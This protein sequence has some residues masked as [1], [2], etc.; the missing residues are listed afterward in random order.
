VGGRIGEVVSREPAGD[1]CADDGARVLSE[2]WVLKITI[3]VPP[4]VTDWGK[5]WQLLRPTASFDQKTCTWSTML[6]AIDPAALT[7]LQSCLTVAREYRAPVQVEVI[8]AP[9]QWLG[10]VFDALPE[11]GTEKPFE[12]LN[13]Q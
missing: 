7:V 5:Q 1:S 13:P 12:P 4:D 6:G 10:P 11:G 9:D 2:R 3:S 8:P